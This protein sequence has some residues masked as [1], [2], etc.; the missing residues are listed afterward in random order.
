MMLGNGTLFRIRYPV[1]PNVFRRTS[2]NLQYSG[3]LP[4]ASLKVDHRSSRRNERINRQAEGQNRSHVVGRSQEAWHETSVVSR[5]LR[6]VARG[7][8]RPGR[9]GMPAKWTVIMLMV[10]A[11]LAVIASMIH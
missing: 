1:N 7:S 3:R 6:P 5:Q 8:P 4:S 10:L 2:G 9:P 11:G